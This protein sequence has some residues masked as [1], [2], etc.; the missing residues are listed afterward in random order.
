MTPEQLATQKVCIS[1]SSLDARIF[2]NN[3]G[4][5]KDETGRM[6]RFGLGND[7]S[8]G[9]KQ[10]KF[11]DY[12]GFTSIIITPDMVGQKIAVFTNLEIKPE[13]AMQKTMTA[14]ASLGSREN[15]QWETCNF[16]KDYGGFAGFVTNEKDVQQVLT[17]QLK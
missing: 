10:L 13:G 5:C 8:K 3:S 6:I 12:I 16:V 2:R 17:W 14:A 1:A 9:N 11:G 7:G 15:L 4:G